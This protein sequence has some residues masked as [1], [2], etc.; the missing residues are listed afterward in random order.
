MS[1]RV[2]VVTTDELNLTRPCRARFIPPG[3]G[4]DDSPVQCTRNLDT[5]SS[6]SN[7]TRNSGD[8]RLMKND[9]GFLAH[10]HQHG[11]WTWF[12]DEDGIV[13]ASTEL[14][15]EAGTEYTASIG[16]HIAEAERLLRLAG[17]PSDV[18]QIVYVASVHIQLAALKLDVRNANPRVTA[19]PIQ[20]K[21]AEMM[22][23]AKENR[24]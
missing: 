18:E 4:I 7:V 9:S 14:A 24:E 13:F 6:P 3:A 20:V 10:V 19:G 17:T 12:G 5:F 11:N 8:H 1:T 21:I 16:N 2:V 22:N 23:I 15:R